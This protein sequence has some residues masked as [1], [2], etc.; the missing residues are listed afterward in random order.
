MCAHGT[1]TSRSKK[2]RSENAVT[3][4]VG[5][6]DRVC[7][8]DQRQREDPREDEVRRSPRPAGAQRATDDEAE[9]DAGDAWGAVDGSERGG[10]MLAVVI[11]D[12]AGHHHHQQRAAGTRERGAE[13]CD[14]PAG[15]DAEQH[16]ASGQARRGDGEHLPA[17]DAIDQLHAEDTREQQAD[18]ER[19]A[20]QR[21]HHAADAELVAQFAQHHTHAEPGDEE[22]V[23][24]CR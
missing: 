12:E 7:H 15:P 17:P 20:V 22:A 2:W 11:A 18:A 9:G 23:A 8:H 10:A 19:A 3:L 14:R 24:E 6:G 1:S 21:G 4:T 13:Q 16:H 5:Q